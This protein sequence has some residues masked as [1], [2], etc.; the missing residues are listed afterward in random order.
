[1][2]ANRRPC[3]RRAIGCHPVK[4]L[5][6]PTGKFQ[7]CRC[8]CSCHARISSLVT[9]GETLAVDGLPNVGDA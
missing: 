7:D 5:L 9:S 4:T 1:M 8:F 2:L 6:R 3:F